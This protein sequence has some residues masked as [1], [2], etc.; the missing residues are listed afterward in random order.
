MVPMRPELLIRQERGLFGVWG[1]GGTDIL[2][3]A[4]GM[5]G[6]SGLLFLALDPNF[7]IRGYHNIF[8]PIFHLFKMEKRF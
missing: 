7:V 1:K 5:G 2:L 8:K 3:L 4:N 6:A